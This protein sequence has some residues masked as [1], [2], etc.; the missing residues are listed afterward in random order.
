MLAVL[1]AP[2]VALNFTV[3]RQDDAARDP[4][5]AETQCLAVGGGCTLRA[6]IETANI[7]TG[8]HNIGFDA[9]MVTTI[10][11][12]STLPGITAPVNIDGTNTNAASGNRVEIDG[13][14]SGCLSLSETATPSNAN[15]ARGSTIANLVI[16]NCSGNGISLSGHGYTVTGNRIG[17]NAAGTASDPASDGNGGH[18]ISLSGTVGP[19]SPLPDIL[20]LLDDLPEDFGGIAAFSAALQTALTVIAPPNT[21]TGNLISGNAESGIELFSQNTVNTFIAGNIIGLDQSAGTALPNGHGGGN[22]AGIRI[23]SGAYGN[24]V[25][26]GNIV[27]GQNASDTDD[28]MQITPGQV[29][30]P[31]FVMG[32][33]VG[34]GNN[35]LAEVGNG[36][37][38]IVV[39]TTP[40]PDNPTALSLVLGPAN[41]VSDNRSDPGTGL[42]ASG[43]DTS[44]GVLI[45]SSSHTLV[46]GNFIGMFQF[47][48][49]G[50]PIGELDVGNDGNGIVVT[51]GNHQIL[52]NLILG[53]GRHGILL[54]G[55]VAG[56][57]V[58]IRRNFI[59]VSDFTGLDVFDFGNGG[60]GIQVYG[61]PVH[62][63][64]GLGADEGNV[65]AGNGR[66]GVKLSELSTSN[67]KSVLVARNAI[68][69]N[70][71]GGT[72][73]AIDLAGIGAESDVANAVDNAVPNTN[74]PNFRQNAPVLCNN[75]GALPACD[76]LPP[77]TLDTG[78]G[79]MSASFAVLSSPNTPLRIEFY[80]SDAPCSAGTGEGRTF[81]GSKTVTTDGT[82]LYVE[83][84]GFSPAAN[85]QGNCIAL[86]A[87]NLFPLEPDNG[88]GYPE[89]RLDGSIGPANATS[90]FSNG[91]LLQ[92]PGSLQFDP[93]SHDFGGVAVGD[94]DDFAFS[95]QHVAGD[96]VT[97]ITLVTTGD[98]YSIT[99][100][101]CGPEP[102]DL[103]PGESCEVTVRFA[104][105]AG[106]Q[107]TGQLT[108]N[109]TVGNGA[110]AQLEGT[111]LAPGVLDFD[112]DSLDFGDVVVGDHDTLGVVLR[113]LGDTLV[114]NVTLT[115]TGPGYS[116]QGGSCP[117]VAFNLGG[118]DTCTVI[119][120]FEP[121]APGSASG[122][123]VASGDGSTTS[124]ALE[125]NGLAP[126][127]LAFDLPS[128]GFGN[129]PIGDSADLTATL[130]NGG[131]VA[132]TNVVVTVTGAGFSREGGSCGMGAFDLPGGDS[133]TVLLRFE[134]AA[135]GAASGEVRASHDGGSDA[136]ADL[137]GT[138]L[139]PGALA[140]DPASLD[141][142]GVPVGDSDT[143][144]TSLEN[145]GAVAVSGIVLA[146][147]GPGFSRDGGDC[148]AV[149]FSL[150]PG[151]GCSVVVRFAPAVAGMANGSLLATSTDGGDASASLTGNG[152]APGA[153]AFVPAILDFGDVPVGSSD[154]LTT[155]LE[156]TGA[157]A[158]TGI[159]LAVAGSGFSR[160]GGDC[161]AMAFSLDPGEDCSV[162]VRFEPAASGMANGSLDAASTD[163]GSAAA[164]LSGT[165]LAPGEL[166]F[167]VASL[168]FGMIAVGGAGATLTA[169]LA[170]PGD[171]PVTSVEIAVTG[172]GFSRDGGSCDSAS[173]TL[174]GGASCTVI[175]RF[176][177]TVPG[178]ASGSLDA[179][180]D[181]AAAVVA[182]TGEG[183]E[184]GALV[185]DPDALAFGDVEIGASDTRTTTL[186]N[187]GSETVTGIAV[188]VT[189][190]G[191]SRD[192]GS[193]GGA[194]FQL[195]AGGACTVIVRFAPT[196]A[197]LASG[198]L[199]ATSDSDPAAATLAGNGV[200]PPPAPVSFDPPGGLAFGGVPIGD[201]ADLA[202]TIQ[203]TGSS[204]L[205]GIT[206]GVGGDF[207][208]VGEN[209]APV[210]AMG[211]QCQV[212][213]RF[214]PTALGPRTG[215]FSLGADGGVGASAG[216]SGNGLPAGGIPAPVAVPMLDR[217]GLLLLVLVLVGVG[218]RGLARATDP[219]R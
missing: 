33:L 188:T 41:T 205:S 97:G 40:H 93:A 34:P 90:E 73:I 17:T 214:S 210:L 217:I 150:D 98:A 58:R 111:G 200:E 158:V 206:L 110:S 26:P 169:N 201:D 151:E 195:T 84:D 20:A 145:T 115:V 198:S 208:I 202:L 218:L 128:Y 146:V 79:I 104:P 216:L 70:G 184:P 105:V 78:T 185:F 52:G 119:V 65:I 88:P 187:E 83:S 190:A 101:D 133:C 19:P 46:V 117:M 161:P 129:V 59:G 39:S 138:G 55:G 181:G 6:A 194:G 144:T 77:P 120:R 28:G 91:V 156:N 197:G 81:L 87:T 172:A 38:G 112:P 212:T 204:D 103:G 42:D 135:A 13:N 15:G 63:I 211:A 102:F 82:G 176:Q 61:S 80:G 72:G 99:A 171:L 192:G 132:A 12:A 5:A 215:T 152:L 37:N 96:P 49:G 178:A 203:N 122:S 199:T 2:A 196:L 121:A 48:A 179:T 23:L 136:A 123:L 193:C 24:L 92:T 186:R 207:S 114:T 10:T 29:R 45:T 139:E 116:R 14:D 182:L 22:R 219:R 163:G 25:G 108:A 75:G 118:S 30:L 167:N 147:S 130:T 183:F 47:P 127:M 174:A 154:T 53:N 21:I 95:L 168:D 44:G 69:G 107:A 51:S 164:A 3:N 74:Y 100:S 142:G 159:Q 94:D 175:V 148:P 43:G 124:A 31:N 160:D 35:P 213:I 18:G 27:S 140:F 137:Q 149:A 126:A 68:Y 165:G 54:R 125:G 191:F 153:L 4:G 89:S 8:P 209:C 66:N 106:G 162:T 76:G 57:N 67:T 60:D 86:T 134:P 180:G 1:A 50:S 157:V 11:L 131:E 56:A 170:N 16:R 9:G 62:E 71:Q 36:D 109:A 113:N 64:G 189:G 173:F 143:L 32:N 166:A 155:T 141:F 7:N 85:P 177:P